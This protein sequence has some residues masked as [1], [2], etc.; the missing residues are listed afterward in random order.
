MYLVEHA[1][2][3]VHRRKRNRM[4]TIQLRHAAFAVLL[5]S[6]AFLGLQPAST[7]TIT[8]QPHGLGTIKVNVSGVAVPIQHKHFFAQPATP[9]STTTT[10]ATLSLQ[11]SLEGRGDCEDMQIDSITGTL[12]IGS[13][14][15]WIIQGHGIIN[16]HGYVQITA[17]TALGNHK[18]EL[19]LHGKLQGNNVVFN[20]PQSKL[21]SQYFLSLSG[22][23]NWVTYFTCTTTRKSES[24]SET[25]RESKTVTWTTE[26]D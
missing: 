7:S 4:I 6:A 8:T 9:T 15:Y 21:S 14:T 23:A 16:K 25:E 18:Y 11:G 5:I 13:T 2:I 22:T 3:I 10:T 19:V 26:S 1:I 20:S 24:E 17:R 12:V